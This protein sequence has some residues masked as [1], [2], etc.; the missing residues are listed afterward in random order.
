MEPSHY[1]AAAKGSAMGIFGDHLRIEHLRPF[2]I[3][4]LHGIIL[5]E[6]FRFHIPEVGTYA[7][8]VV[9][10][11]DA[12]QDFRDIN[13]LAAVPG[14]KIEAYLAKRGDVSDFYRRRVWNRNLDV[15]G[16]GVPL[17]IWSKDLEYVTEAAYPGRKFL[18]WP[19]GEAVIEFLRETRRG[20][21]VNERQFPFY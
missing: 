10:R 16:A 11:G 19:L 17:G 5:A 21:V 15:V 9:A 13:G 4:S 6:D 2:Q 7:F 18:G 3:K 20:I 12:P 8:G 1:I 14:V